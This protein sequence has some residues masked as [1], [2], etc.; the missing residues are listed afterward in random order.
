M[1][2]GGGTHDVEVGASANEAFAVAERALR[3][4]GNVKEVN[5]AE[6]TVKGSI[7]YGLQTIL[8]KAHVEQRGNASTIVLKAQGDDLWGAGARKALGR[9]ADALKERP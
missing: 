4:V 7:R 6:R 9:W 1:P 3:Q 5:A 2:I 8:V